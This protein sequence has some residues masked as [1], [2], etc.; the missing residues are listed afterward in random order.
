MAVTPRPGIGSRQSGIDTG[1]RLP[2]P[3]SRLP[4]FTQLDVYR[5]RI[6]RERRL[7]YLA[8]AFVGVCA[9]WTLFALLLYIDR[10]PGALLPLCVLLTVAL[11]LASLAYEAAHRPS[12]A[13]TA[14]LLDGLLDNQQRLVT[15]VELLSGEKASHLSQAQLASTANILN[16]ID[17]KALYPLRVPVPAVSLSLAL[18]LF[19]MAMLLLKGAGSSFVAIQPG[20][21]P[22]D[23]SAEGALISPTPASGLPESGITPTQDPASG[24]S[25]AEATPQGSS[26]STD[27]ASQA[28]ASQQAQSSL[29]RLREAL[30]G[31][32]AAQGAADSLRQG[33]YGDAAK[34]LSE[35][36]EQNDQL[37]PAAKED[38]A[39][40]L[41]QAAND[42]QTQDALR[43]AEQNAADALRSGDYK[44]TEQALKDLGSAVEQAAGNVVPQQDLAKNFPQGADQGGEQNS[45]G[46][47]GNQN[48]QQGQQSGDSSQNGQN[49]QGQQSQ[50]G[51]GEQQ[52]AG[53]S[54]QQGQGG[55]S[56]SQ[57][58]QGDQGQ[59]GSNMGGGDESGQEGQGTAPGEG[60][61]VSGPVDPSRPDVKSNPFE[62]DGQGNPNNTRPVDK[63]DDPALTLEGTGSS[64]AA[65]APGSGSTLNTPGES[66]D[67]PVDRWS[68]I[69]RYFGHDRK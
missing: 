64:G 66:N 7:R 37:S 62:L 69:Q 50:Q 65:S 42:T 18:L 55:S 26:T 56:G 60:H 61:R 38:L 59:S 3:D 43:Y 27:P 8:F 9:A 14:R 53:S 32:S 4:I 5:R 23:Q 16:R 1:S 40:A 35:L 15:S 51:Q 48:S 6:R 63:S 46:S 24:Q 21:L 68:V 58:Q 12:D 39:D 52:G 2:T 49:G 13:E 29:D 45:Q 54:E 57:G 25:S 33:K 47:Q 31:Q 30:D 10:L 19:A 28:G 20:Q 41:E 22:P 11:P 34:Q 36:G 17:P 67:L 44:R